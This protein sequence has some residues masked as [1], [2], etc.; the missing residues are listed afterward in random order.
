MVVNLI[1][2]EKCKL[3]RICCYQWEGFEPPNT[4][5]TYASVYDDSAILCKKIVSIII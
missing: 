5:P 4:P 3:L 1:F 2:C